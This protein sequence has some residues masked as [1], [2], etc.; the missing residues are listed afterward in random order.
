M[1]SLELEITELRQVKKQNEKVSAKNNDYSHIFTS[2]KLMQE[3]HNSLK[4]I[5]IKRGVSK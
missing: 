2:A 3:I 1:S 4:N 5:A